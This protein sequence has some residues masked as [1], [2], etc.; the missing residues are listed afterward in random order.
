M[1]GLAFWQ[2]SL[3]AIEAAILNAT[4]EESTS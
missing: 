2:A 3:K 4:S 1:N